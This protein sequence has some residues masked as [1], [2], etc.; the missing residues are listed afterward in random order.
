MRLK[1][2]VIGDGRER[3]VFPTIAEKLPNQEN[4]SGTT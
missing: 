3:A 2:T 1:L 4:E